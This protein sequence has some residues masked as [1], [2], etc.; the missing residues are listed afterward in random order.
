[1]RSEE[2]ERVTRCHLVS[3][4]PIMTGLK[5]VT[6]TKHGSHLLIYA[7]IT[8][9]RVKLIHKGRDLASFPS[10][11]FRMGPGNKAKRLVRCALMILRCMQSLRRLYDAN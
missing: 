3:F 6:A 5:R 11:M 2:E 8:Q 9:S 1:M 7:R 4:L 10:P